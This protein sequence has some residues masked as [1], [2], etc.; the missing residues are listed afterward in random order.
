[1]YNIV[2][3]IEGILMS[4]KSYFDVYSIDF[5]KV[6]EFQS[7]IQSFENTPLK[8]SIEEAIEAKLFKSDLEK[9]KRM[10]SIFALAGDEL[11]ELTECITSKEKGLK[12]FG[13][14]DPFKVQELVHHI[15]GVPTAS[16]SK[17]SLEEREYYF[18][19]MR[20][21]QFLATSLSSLSECFA[22][23][24]RAQVLELFKN[25]PNINELNMGCG[26]ANNYYLGSCK[27]RRSD[28][29]GDNCLRIDFSAAAGPHL[30]VDMHN[31]AFWESISDGCFNKISDH[32]YGC[33]LFEDPSS[34]KTLQSIHRTL[35]KG[36][37]LE[38]DHCFNPDHVSLLRKCGFEAQVE[39]KVAKKIAIIDES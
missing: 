21:T 10:Q 8:T 28:S 11:P 37:C 12:E 9:E 39:E 2:F 17:T 29:H 20:E 34:E 36:G 24:I 6:A 18:Q 19:A 35:A 16:V 27:F 1:M 33:F 32:T 4:I 7:R 31:P 14:A 26:F 30:V 13:G 22:V 15:L 3:Y 38:M 23:D 25:N 5:S